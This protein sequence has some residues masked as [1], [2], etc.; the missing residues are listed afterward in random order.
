MVSKVHGQ[1][2]GKDVLLWTLKAGDLE[3]TISEY[4]A[5]LVSLKFMGKEMTLCHDE[6][7]DLLNRDINPHYGATCGRVAGRIAKA[8]FALNDTTYT[9]PANNGSSCL[10]GGTTGF[11]MRVWTSE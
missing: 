6:L 10:H 9:L 2:N 11:S 7:P 1:I 5:T 3:A 4:G 8:Q